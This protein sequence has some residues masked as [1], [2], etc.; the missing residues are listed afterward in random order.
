M[1]LHPSVDIEGS[2]R[3]VGF[4]QVRGQT[5]TGSVWQW[6]RLPADVGGT[7]IPW[8]IHVADDGA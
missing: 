6:I 8:M 1:D 4:E 2:D 5:E 7:V 3:T